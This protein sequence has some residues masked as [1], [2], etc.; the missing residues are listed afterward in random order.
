MI[1][2]LG[3]LPEIRKRELGEEDREQRIR[4]RI[5]NIIDGL[6]RKIRLELLRSV[7]PRERLLNSA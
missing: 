6:S 4:G 2:K 5:A 7:I 1:A 3:S